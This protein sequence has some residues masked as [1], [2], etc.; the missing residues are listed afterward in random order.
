MSWIIFIAFHIVMIVIQYWIG[1]ISF[2]IHERD[3]TRY[4]DRFVYWGIGLIVMNIVVWGL[5]GIISL[6]QWLM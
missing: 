3:W 1:R 5:V 2:A 6:W 4:E